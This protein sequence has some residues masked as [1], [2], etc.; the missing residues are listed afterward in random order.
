VW[1]SHK[2]KKKQRKA[3]AVRTGAKTLLMDMKGMENEGTAER[4]GKGVKEN[5]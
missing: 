3:M 4:K 5:G 2:K 1:A